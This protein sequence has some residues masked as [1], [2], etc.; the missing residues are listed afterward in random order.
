MKM[1]ECF[2]TFNLFRSQ[3]FDSF[4]DR[5][6]TGDKTN[7]ELKHV[8][9]PYSRSNCLIRNGF[10]FKCPNT[11]FGNCNDLKET[12]NRREKEEASQEICKLEEKNFAQLCTSETKA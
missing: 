12:I 6:T 10:Q 9:S 4:K 1:S 11:T 7:T 5:S 2:A 3:R 8:Y